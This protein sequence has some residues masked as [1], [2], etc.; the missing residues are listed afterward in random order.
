[1]VYSVFWRNFFSLQTDITFLLLPNISVS[2]QYIHRRSVAG[3]FSPCEQ[4]QEKFEMQLSHS[5]KKIT[6][7]QANLYM[8][9]KKVRLVGKKKSNTCLLLL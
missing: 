1:M 9:Q 7:L 4:H 5:I 2:V 3:Y 6:I 8:K